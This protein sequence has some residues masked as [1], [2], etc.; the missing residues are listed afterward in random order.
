[1]KSKTGSEKNEFSEGAN[2][3]TKTSEQSAA[4]DEKENAQNLSN[5]KENVDQWLELVFDICFETST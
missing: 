2:F 4:S 1:M 3:M 5:W